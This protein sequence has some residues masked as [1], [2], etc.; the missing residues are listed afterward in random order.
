MADPAELCRFAASEIRAIDRR[1]LDDE[2]RAE[3][4]MLAK[5]VERR[6]TAD[7]VSKVKD[8]SLIEALVGIVDA[9]DT[10][11]G[12]PKDEKKLAAT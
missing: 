1:H 4:F 6:A 3:L 10:L 12:E 8:W 9:I 2:A 5:I 7:T 11:F